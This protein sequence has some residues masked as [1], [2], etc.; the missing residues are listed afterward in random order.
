MAWTSGNCGWDS[1]VSTG[2]IVWRS[3]LSQGESFRRGQTGPEAYP[4]SCTIS[5]GSFPGVKWLEC[6]ADHTPPFHARLLT[7]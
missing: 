5:T 3:H 1:S 4:A 2:W 6:G 7:V